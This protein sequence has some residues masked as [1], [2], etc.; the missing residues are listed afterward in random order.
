MKE[1]VESS[2]DSIVRDTPEEDYQLVMSHYQGNLGE[3][4]VEALGI[5][6]PDPVLPSA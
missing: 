3:I 5:A 2:H 4:K 6:F 1:D